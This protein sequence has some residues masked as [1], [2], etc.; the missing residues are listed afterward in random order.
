MGLEC[1]LR[2]PGPFDKLALTSE[3]SDLLREYALQRRASAFRWDDT[4]CPSDSSSVFVCARCSV[5]EH[6]VYTFRDCTERF[7]FHN[8][9]RST[10]SSSSVKF[11]LGVKKGNTPTEQMFSVILP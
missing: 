4:D 11:L 6:A 10:R 7:R 5:E 2:I 9:L 8:L 3:W 1:L